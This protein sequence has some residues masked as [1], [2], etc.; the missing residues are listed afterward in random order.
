MAID[1]RRREDEHTWTT[2]TYG[3]GDTVILAGLDLA[4][5]VEAFYRGIML[6]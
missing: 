5:P 6:V 3:P 4:I 2:E 1:V